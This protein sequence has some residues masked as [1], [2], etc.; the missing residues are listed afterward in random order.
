MAGA[1]LMGQITAVTP[2]GVRVN[3]IVPTRA[4]VRLEVTTE[5]ERDVT[6]IDKNSRSRRVGKGV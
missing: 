4:G 2:L 5:A 6:N 3:K 1:D